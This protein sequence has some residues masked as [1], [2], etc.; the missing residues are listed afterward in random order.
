MGKS[1]NDRGGGRGPWNFASTV[2]NTSTWM[3]MEHTTRAQRRRPEHGAEAAAPAG[4]HHIG[5]RSCPAPLLHPL[6]CWRRGAAEFSGSICALPATTPSHAGR[7][8]PVACSG[9][10]AALV[11]D[12]IVLSVGGGCRVGGGRRDERESRRWVAGP[13]S[14]RDLTVQKRYATFREKIRS[15]NEV[16]RERPH[17]S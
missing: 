10:L 15:Y 1:Q 9:R 8:R 6:S 16:G 4:A 17:Q 13:T 3:W 12:E 11:G 14:V 7:N 2:N 5:A